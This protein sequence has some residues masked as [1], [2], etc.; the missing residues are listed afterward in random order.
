MFM[1]KFYVIG[2]SDNPKP[3]FAPEVLEVIRNGRVFSGGKRH[4]EIVVPFLPEGAEW[5]DITVPLDAVFEQYK[6]SSIFNLQPLARR[7]QSS[8]FNVT[9][10]I[11]LGKAIKLAEG[12]L[13]THSKKQTMNKAFI[14]EILQE[15]GCDEKTIAKVKDI[16]L[17]RELWGII[18]TE[19][20]EDFAH[21][22]IA[23][24]E[25]HCRPLLPHGKLTVLLIDDE[26]H[27]Y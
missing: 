17:A 25:K 14:V 3:W 22:V 5:I 27:I 13:D 18:P 2:I 6:Q 8:I 10:G 21:T 16:T 20:L 24:C 15:A 23:H 4:H 7:S 1:Q 9:L 11:M 26:G 12:H 19:Q